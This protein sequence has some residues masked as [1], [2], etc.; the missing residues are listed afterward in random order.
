MVSPTPIGFGQPLTEDQVRPIT[1]DDLGLRV[2]Y[3]GTGGTPQ[4]ETGG[5]VDIV[6][7]HGMGA[8]PDDTWCK[9][10]DGDDGPVYVNW[11][12]HERFLRA[13]VLVDAHMERKRWPGIYD[14]TVGLVFL[15]TPFR[16]TH[17]SLSQGEILMRAQELFTETPVYGENLGILRTGTES[18]TDLVD[19]YFRIARQS[20]MPRVACFYE[21]GASEVGGILRKDLG[22]AIPSVILVN[23]TSG[24]LDLNEKSDKYALPRTHF[25]IQKFGSP[26]E[27][28]FRL[29]GSVVQ[30]MVEE[31]PQLISTRAQCDE[32]KNGYRVADLTISHPRAG[33]CIKDLRVTDPRHDK[34]RIEQTKGGLLRDSYRWILDHHDF[35]RWRDDPDSRLLWIKGDPGK[36]KTMLLCGIIDELKKQP[37]NTT[38]LLSF[39]FCQATDDRLNNG[40]AILRGL[41]YLLVDQ[42]RSLLSHIQEKYNHAGKA[43]FDD[44][45][46]WVA[47]S[48]ILT[49][50][51]Q[52]PS[53]PDTTLVIDALDEYGTDLAQLLDLIIQLSISSRVKW[54]VSSRNWPH[55][56][57]YLD[58][59]T[60]KVK[61]CLELNESS[62]SHAVRIYI[63]YKVDQL[64]RSKKYDDTL[65]ST[66]QDYMALNANDTFLWVAM[67]YH[68]LA[69]PKVRS[70]NTLAK[71]RAFPPGLNSLY[72]RMMDQI[73][74]SEDV[75]ICKQV[76][77]VAS[78][79][80][81]PLTLRELTSLVESLDNFS[82]N[83]ECLKE[84]IK[85]CAVE[86][87]WSACLSTL[88]GHDDS[89]FSVAFSP[90]GSRLASGS[91][92]RTVKVWDAATGACLSTLAGHRDLV[93]SVAFSPDGSRLASGSWDCTV[94]VWDAATGAC[95]LMLEGH[96]DLVNSVTFSPD[97]R[98]LAS[99]SD[100]C[101]VKVWDA[102]TGACLSTL[103]GHGD[104]VIS[105][106]FSPDGSRL[107]SG[108]NDCTVKV[109]DAAT[110]ACLST[111]EGHGDSVKSVAFSPDGSRLASGSWDC[112]I[113]VWDAVTG[114][115]LSMLEGHR[116]LVY[117]V[118]FSPDG[119]R[120][121]SGSDDCA[122]KVWDA[123]TGACLST[124]EGHGD[125]VKS[126]AFSPDGSRLASGS[127]DC[128]VKVWDA[129]TGACLS[130]LEGHGGSVWSVAFS[131]DGNYLITDASAIPL[132]ASYKKRMDNLQR[133]EPALA[134]S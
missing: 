58:I 53:L 39:F 50:I 120:L 37:A 8:H 82:D 106:A 110:G 92:D 5:P 66:V 72:G 83:F 52:D 113:K 86:R 94:K 102:A 10:V 54:I 115:Y 73:I 123:T 2:L 77:A 70:W 85:F 40:T 71:L 78:V 24:S 105:V 26:G 125:S 20:A 129:A 87:N 130:T 128:T 55:I 44:V 41:I 48:D 75:Q 16:G 62:I 64:A 31:G 96:G 23:E 121:A 79:V 126:V 118:A 133:P 15:G 114:A 35:K 65:R 7:V 117:S 42:Q 100:D 119:S 90:D 18:L 111:L 34:K 103:A 25:D 46:A 76:L 30:T 14:S 4:P 93:I 69:D 17:D 97:G 61:L 127:W 22:K 109:W 43:L 19:T 68:A 131:P 101:T 12:E 132:P 134:A 45:N 29:L 63:Q 81:R 21:Q 49:S 38:R 28:G 116:D 98:R 95:L 67:V 32:N 27:Q 57:Q 1:D 47:L 88:A 36:G 13:V 107:A 80:Y 89:V 6:A 124:F 104:L 56:E 33:K 3:D 99:G 11:L 91:D 51:L 59:A 122:V 60:Q 112:T 108:S 84:I 9:K 74:E